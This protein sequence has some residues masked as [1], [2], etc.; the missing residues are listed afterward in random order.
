M[1][2]SEAVAER[3]HAALASVDGIRSVT[4]VGSFVD[5]ENLAGISDI[6]TVVVFDRL[7]PSRCT[8]AVSA[9]GALTGDALGFPGH[10]V[11]VNTILGPLKCDQHGRIVVHLMLYD[12]ASHR[13][14][15]LR[16]PFTCLDW[17]RSR[18]CRG[19]RLADLYPVG[20][21]A[22]GDFETARRGLADYI[23]D[24]QS[25]T[26]SVRR[27][28]PD[29]DTIVEVV[30]RVSLDRRHQGRY[31]Y[32]IIR[33]L[34]VNLLKMRT[35]RNQLWDEARLCRDWRD[36]PD[37]A[38]WLPFYERI[39]DVKTAG[40][41]DFPPDTLPGTRAFVEAVQVSLA[42]ALDGAFRLRLVRH[43]K[44]SLNN[45]TFLG[46]GRDPAL[47]TADDVQ[48]YADQFDA[49]FS[50]PL[51][52]A[53]ETARA[54]APHAAVRVDARL[55]E[56]NYGAAEGCTPGE[57]RKRFPQTVEA[58]NRGEDPA[59]PG[60]ETTEDVL[61]RARAF[62]GSLGQASGRALAVTHNVVMRVIVAD[63]LGLDVR[64][65]YRLPIGHLEALDICRIEGRWVPDWDA[66]VKARLMD[67]FVGCLAP[68]G[69]DRAEWATA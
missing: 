55:T 69:V 63:L 46:S 21:L 18:S 64:K 58:W 41:D 17:Q 42:R 48:P 34:V 37:L 12:R 35:G 68:R 23:S 54:L 47:A 5:R 20:C 15:V 40:R 50:S 25:G 3:I 39:R 57:F 59:F 2:R 49:L 33:N 1:S 24:V 6:D 67:G 61:R 9:V 53:V 30:D 43:A 10:A 13:Q 32:H 7:T 22:P 45:G 51:R 65:A 66:T 11:H 28:E 14:H 36:M 19:V 4:L 60:G 44:T 29:G 8:Q 26:L 31:A 16:S 27:L 52:R 38:E 56:I 62:L